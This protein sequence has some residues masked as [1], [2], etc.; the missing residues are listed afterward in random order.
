MDR[1]VISEAELLEFINQKLHGL[2]F[3]VDYRNYRFT[4][5]VRLQLEDRDGVNWSGANYEVDGIADNKCKPVLEN[6][7]KDARTK[8]NVE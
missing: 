1:K 7:I 4:E 8:Y 6:I 5:I 3:P 2:V